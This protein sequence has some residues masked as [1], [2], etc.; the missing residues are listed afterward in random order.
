MEGFSYLL[1][2]VLYLA[3]LAVLVVAALPLASVYA[4]MPEPERRKY[5][6]A[7]AAYVLCGVFYAISGYG[8][9]VDFLKGD[10]FS[11]E[12]WN[13]FV[14]FSPTFDWFLEILW[15]SIGWTSFVSVSAFCI[16]CCWV[17]LARKTSTGET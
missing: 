1:A 14:S 13:V 9:T 10:A 8:I 16:F 7:V 11:G 15:K 5:G 12:Y 2:V 6:W 3:S 4:N 17:L